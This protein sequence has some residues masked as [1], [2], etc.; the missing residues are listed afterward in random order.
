MQH[1]V[2]LN[3]HGAD[4]NDIRPFQIG[5]SYLADIDVDQTLFP[6]FRQQRSNRQQSQRGKDGF[7]AFK[8]QGVLETPV[9]IGP[10]RIHKKR[11]H[12][13]DSACVA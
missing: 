3:E 4:H 2:F 6:A 9:R 5:I 11:F 10:L 12:R 13:D 7:L 1:A 8:G